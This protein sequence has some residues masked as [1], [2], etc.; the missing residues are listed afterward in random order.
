[1]GLKAQATSAVSCHGGN[2]GELRMA[3]MTSD[4]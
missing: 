4:I 2:Y 1:L 3:G